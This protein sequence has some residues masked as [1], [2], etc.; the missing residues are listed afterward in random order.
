[1]D[2]HFENNVFV[3]RKESCPSFYRHKFAV[4]LEMNVFVYK[5]QICFEIISLIANN[6]FLISFWFNYFWRNRVSIL[7]HP[8]AMPECIKCISWRLIVNLESSCKKDDFTVYNVL[9]TTFNEKR[10]DQRE[11]TEVNTD[12][13]VILLFWKYEQNKYISIYLIPRVIP[14]RTPHRTAA[15]HT[16]KTRSSAGREYVHAK[17]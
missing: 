17:L 16:H 15:E 2:H 8:S 12:F 3:L 5:W 9:V 10:Y 13:L 4:V 1:M 7:W 6:I 11:I 14:H